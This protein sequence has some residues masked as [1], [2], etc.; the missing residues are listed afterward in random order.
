M[1]KILQWGVRG[2][3]GGGAEIDAGRLPLSHLDGGGGGGVD[4]A[5]QLF[6]LRI[7]IPLSRSSFS[8]L[9]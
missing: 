8:F 9:L 5:L 1:A 6:A 3:G 2:W 4:V 7:C